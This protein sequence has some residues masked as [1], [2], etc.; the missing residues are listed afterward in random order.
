LQQR[1]REVSGHQRSP[2]FEGP[3][4]GAIEADAIRFSFDGRHE[5]ANISF[6]FEGR[7]A[8]GSMAGT[9]ALGAASDQ[10]S[11][12]VNKS[13]FGSGSWEARRVA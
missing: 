10:N 4:S 8:N 6:R 12:I 2:Q 13:Q 5:A 3:V 7:V 1:G 9:V 11:G